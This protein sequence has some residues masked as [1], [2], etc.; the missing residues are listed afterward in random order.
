MPGRPN[1]VYNGLGTGIVA[2]GAMILN[3]LVHDNASGGIIVLGGSLATGNTV[4]GHTG[5]QIIGLQIQGGEARGNSI[6]GNFDGLLIGNGVAADNRIF[7][8]SDDGIIISGGTV[9]GNVVY[10]NRVGITAQF[11]PSILGNL[12]Y[13][14]AALGISITTAGSAVIEGNTV[15]Q[16]AGDA[17]RV[18]LDLNNTRLNS[19]RV[20]NNLLWT[21]G[22]G[23]Y[24][25]NVSNDSDTGFVSD[26]NNLYATGTAK[27]ARWSIQEFATLREW[28]WELGLDVHGISADPQFVDPDGPDDVLG[29]RPASAGAPGDFG[30]DDNFRVRPGSPTIDAADPLSPWFA[31]PLPNGGRANLGHYGNTPST[32]PSA[33]GQL[34]QVVSP[35]GGEKVQA[36][37]PLTVDW[38]SSGLTQTRVAGLLN[39]GGAAVASPS[40]EW[41]SAEQYAT[42]RLN[43]T[44]SSPSVLNT[45]P[46]PAPSR[47]TGPSVLRTPASA[48]SWATGCP[49]QTARTPSACTGT[50]DLSRPAGGCS[51]SSFRA[52][53]SARTSTCTRRREDSL[54]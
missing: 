31:E 20:R 12:V 2:T 39:A 47:S 32:T 52:P 44:S 49:S 13:G 5:N 48:T 9:R 41:G 40:G 38:R 23:S 4:Y 42:T 54:A 53:W 35:N 14:N 11:S 6:F 22:A 51:T 46:N 10:S 26:F 28:A 37:R 30:V 36:G 17:L 34:I 24:A 18:S 50:K 27:V 3:N 25:L 7:N 45:I 16:L 19:S 29:Y 21:S 1:E 8:N 43:F 33:P 15:Y